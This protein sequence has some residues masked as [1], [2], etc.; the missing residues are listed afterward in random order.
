MRPRQVY[1]ER[2]RLG[3]PEADWK[4]ANPL[5]LPETCR[6][7]PAL[8]RPRAA[9]LY[10]GTTAKGPGCACTVGETARARPSRTR[11]HCDAGHLLR[12]R[13]LP[14]SLPGHRRTA[15][16]HVATP[17]ADP[18][19]RS[20]RLAVRFPGRGRDSD[21][22]PSATQADQLCQALGLSTPGA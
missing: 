6:G 8:A 17:A 22:F 5:T 20:R 18:V 14:D 16:P 10:S 21:V 1:T 13:A 11:L 9:R 3:R 2:S 7:F 15:V 4:P 19:L 12:R